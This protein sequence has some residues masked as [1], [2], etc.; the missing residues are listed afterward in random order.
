MQM[1][2]FGCSRN[3]LQA[4]VSALGEMHEHLW[5]HPAVLDPKVPI[6]T[7]EFYSGTQKKLQALSFTDEKME[8]ARMPRGRLFIFNWKNA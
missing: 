2:G 5:S 6:L 3:A 1:K 4:Q 8:A 7:Q